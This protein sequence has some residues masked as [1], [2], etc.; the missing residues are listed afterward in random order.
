[1]QLA[2]Q[3]LKYVFTLQAVQ[4]YR[5][6][7]AA[8][9]ALGYAVYHLSTGE[10]D[11]AVVAVIAFIGLLS[12]KP[13]DGGA[14]T[15]TDP[16]APAPRLS[17]FD[18][19][20]YSRVAALVAVM[21]VAG[22]GSAQPPDRGPPDRGPVAMILPLYQPGDDRG[23]DWFL[24]PQQPV[25]L[26]TTPWPADGVE[27]HATQIGAP[28]A[29]AKGFRGQG[30]VIA[31]LDTGCDTNHPMLQDYVVKS[32]DFSRSRVGSKDANG[33]GT[34]CVS[35]VRSIAPDARCLNVK[36]L[37]DG[38][39]G[40]DADIGT[41]VDWSV[42]NGATI[43]SLSLGSSQPGPYSGPA[44]ARA[45]ARGV[46]VVAAAGNSGP[47]MNTIGYPGALPGVVCVAAVDQT[48]VV[49]RFSSRGDRLDI[50][51]PGVNVSGAAPGGGRV[52]MSGTSMAT[53]LVAGAVAVARSA[54]L[55]GQ[56]ATDKLFAAADDLPPNGRDAN[57]GRGLV[58]PDKATAGVDPPNPN[59]N[60]NP[61]TPMPPGDLTLTE[62]DLNESGR[63]KLHAAG[64]KGFHLD[65][66]WLKANFSTAAPVLLPS[67]SQA[68]RPLP[69]FAPVYPPFIGRCFGGMC[70]R[71]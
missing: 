23:P 53:P 17:V 62:T 56:P 27:Q 30:Q 25:M 8:A 24:P 38:G 9:G 58:R 21:L 35:G 39:S 16:V 26:D 66:A 46:T 15:P 57:T 29:W 44:I 67:P 54:A 52:K 68:F 28:N 22:A 48:N 4:G 69:T 14:P 12:T 50:S 18:Q 70:P 7:I 40:S 61:P 36:V 65:L 45:I 11:K 6:Y 55:A 32:V 60:P 31:V 19:T 64:L 20:A 33:H 49:A 51:A 1:M 37:G 13:G 59:P 41:G 63:A 43:I 10:Y 71:Q 3:I 47:G 2:T 5:A 34:W 42:E